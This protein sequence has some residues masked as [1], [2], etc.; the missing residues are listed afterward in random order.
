VQVEQLAGFV[1]AP[2]D[3]ACVVIVE[4][5]I[6][7]AA[8]EP[9]AHHKPAQQDVIEIG[10]NDPFDVGQRIHARAAG[11]L[12]RGGSEVYGPLRSVSSPA[13]PLSVS[14]PPAPI[15]TSRRASPV[16]VSLALLPVVVRSSA[17]PPP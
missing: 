13:M 6:A 16:R 7:V 9:R 8:L 3:V 15:I 10:P 5:V 12:R 2:P 4:S 17:V 11:V 14:L 1:T